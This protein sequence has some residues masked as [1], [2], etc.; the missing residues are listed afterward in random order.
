MIFRLAFFIKV[1]AKQKTL[2]RI[3]KS[4]K[5]SLDS[6]RLFFEF[7]CKKLLYYSKCLKC[8]TSECV[9]YYHY[10]S[11]ILKFNEFMLKVLRI[12]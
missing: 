9:T 6:T 4:L 7:W 5:I 12:G 3:N 8:I 10:I 2:V 11:I 1:N